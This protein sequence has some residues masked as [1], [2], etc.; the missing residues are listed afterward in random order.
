MI[1]SISGIYPDIA[2]DIVP[3]VTDGKLQLPTAGVQ[4]CN[5]TYQMPKVEMELKDGVVYLT[6]NGYV[7][8][9]DEEERS[10]LEPFP[11]QQ[12]YWLCDVRVVD[13]KE[14]ILTLKAVLEE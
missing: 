1:S 8:I 11:N 3:S 13:G 5:V 6:P 9:T 14:Q 2:W 12:N 7:F 10:S 4:V